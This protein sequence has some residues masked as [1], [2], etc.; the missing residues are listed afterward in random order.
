MLVLCDTRCDRERPGAKVFRVAKVGVGTE[1]AEKGF[2]ERVFGCLAPKQANEVA[3]DLCAVRLV[4]TFEGR[5]G[6]RVHHPV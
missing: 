2:L 5:Y 4:E 6:H 1:C 3:E